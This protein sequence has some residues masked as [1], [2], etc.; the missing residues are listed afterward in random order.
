VYAIPAEDEFWTVPPASP[1]AETLFHPAT[2]DRG[3]ATLEGLRQI[4]GD[5]TFFRIMRRW[6]SENRYGVVTTADFLRLVDSEASQDLDAYFQDWL[7]D[8]DKPSITPA[9]FQ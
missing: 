2:Y 9:D 1:A 4:V 6:H 3:M 8:P 7:Y 5:P